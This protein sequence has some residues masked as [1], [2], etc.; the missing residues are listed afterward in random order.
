MSLLYV[1]TGICVYIN[2]T[3]YNIH[4]MYNIRRSYIYIYCIFRYIYTE[5]T[6]VYA[7]YVYIYTVY[8]PVYTVYMSSLV[9][10]GTVPISRGLC[11]DWAEWQ[12]RTE[13]Y[14]ENLAES[15]QNQVLFTILWFIFNIINN[16]MFQINRCMV[17]T[18]WFGLYLIRF[19]KVSVQ[20]GSGVFR[21]G[22]LRIFCC[23]L[24]LS[25]VNDGNILKLGF[26]L[27]IFQ[28]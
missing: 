14:S 17:D 25:F 10:G 3:P 15:N 13:K 19:V 11:S 21:Y 4:R 8:I 26:S 27:W 1:Y 28:N 7:Y 12:R 6:G 24:L 5:C 9:R 16:V 23:G 2:Y 20:F 18:I 22:I